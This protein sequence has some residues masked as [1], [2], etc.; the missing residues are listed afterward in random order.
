[1]HFLEVLRSMHP[2]TSAA[3]LD[4]YLA[5]IAK[6]YSVEWVPDLTMDEKSVWSFLPCTW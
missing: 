4:A 2:T 3:A 6:S 5:K 1:M